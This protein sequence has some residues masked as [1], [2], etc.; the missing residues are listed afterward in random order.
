MTSQRCTSLESSTTSAG[1]EINVHVCGQVASQLPREQHVNQIIHGADNYI[2]FLTSHLS[3]LENISEF[4]HTVGVYET[5]GLSR[6]EGIETLNSRWALLITN[7]KKKGYD[8]LE[9]R[10]HDFDID[11][12]DFKSQLKE[13]EVTVPIS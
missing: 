13:L 5:L 10:K 2:H 9:H 4:L 11:Y 1:G 8:P 3:R 7:L 6:I 12:D